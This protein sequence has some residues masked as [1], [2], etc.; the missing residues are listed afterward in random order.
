MATSIRA[1]SSIFV[2]ASSS[3]C[4]I[5]LVS[6]L[7]G[8]LVGFLD[9]PD[10][11]LTAFQQVRNLQQQ[12][13]LLCPHAT[14]THE[15]ILLFV[16]QVHVGP[17]NMAYVDDLD[18]A[19]SFEVSSLLKEAKSTKSIQFL[20]DEDDTYAKTVAKNFGCS[21]RRHESWD[22]VR[23]VLRSGSQTI[24]NECACFAKRA[25]VSRRPL[26]WKFVNPRGRCKVANF[27]FL[28]RVKDILYIRFYKV[29]PTAWSD[30]NTK[31]LGIECVNFD[32]A[33]L[34]ALDRLEHLAI[35]DYGGMGSN[36]RKL[37]SL[38]KLRSIQLY[39]KM[40]KDVCQDFL[41]VVRN[42]NIQE[43]VV[44]AYNEYFYDE[45]FVYQ[46]LS[47][48][49]LEYIHIHGRTRKGKSKYEEYFDYGY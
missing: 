27:G 40:T 22:E 20:W 35:R 39:A 42:S 9:L 6:R 1:W 28:K 29:C 16:G 23:V 33:Y 18:E 30:M 32:C 48:P 14:R 19:Q 11:S 12:V 3:P 36:V 25:F 49:R 31:Q 24:P 43:V 17:P 38:D 21:V 10:K 5:E 7:C 44:N 13:S 26:G 37:S 4:K 47:I 15:D 34:E 2:F 46:L 8:K 41:H 45:S